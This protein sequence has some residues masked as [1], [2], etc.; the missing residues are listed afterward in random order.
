MDLPLAKAEPISNSDSTSVIA[1]LRKETKNPNCCGRAAGG[2]RICA[3]NNSADSK[4]SEGG[5]GGT[6]GTRAEIPLQPMVKTMGRQA[7]PLQPMEVQ[8][9]AD[10]HL[11]PIEDPMP[12]QMDAPKGGCDPMESLCW[13]RL[14][15]GPVNPV[16]RGAHAGTSFLAGLVTPWVT[17]AEAVCS[18]RT[19]PRGKHP[20]WNSSWRTASYGKDPMLEQGKTVRSPPPEEEGAAR[21]ICD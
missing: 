12:E 17:H 10:I 2:V 1:Y 8:S 21:T 11:Q 16:E 18:K 14:L 19:S 6:P 20:R 15:A 7:V 5:R 9:G 13:S 4:V 3:S